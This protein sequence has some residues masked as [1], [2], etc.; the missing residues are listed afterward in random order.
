MTEG[1]GDVDHTRAVD[2]DAVG[3]VETGDGERCSVSRAKRS[4]R[5]RIR[6]RHIDSRNLANRRVI[7]IRHI[8]NAVRVDCNTGGKREARRAH[9]TIG[10]RPDTRRSTHR[11]NGAVL[12]NPTNKMVIRIRDVGCAL[13]IHRDTQGVIK[14]GRSAE[15]IDGP[16]TSRRAGQSLHD[17]TGRNTTDRVVVRVGHVDVP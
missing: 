7:G 3:L 8:H 17:A 6:A 15:A 11:G 12:R 16:D 2:G 10:A 13:G 9:G 4:G 5:A 14:P 1:V